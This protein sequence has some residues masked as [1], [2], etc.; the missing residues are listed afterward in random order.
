MNRRAFIHGLGALTVA[1]SSSAHAFDLELQGPGKRSW[2][3]IPSILVLAAEDDPRVAAVEQAVRAW[4]IELFRMGSGFRLGAARHR[5]AIIGA[6]AA[7]TVYD[8]ARGDAQKRQRASELRNRFK[9]IASDIIIVLADGPF[10]GFHTPLSPRPLKALIAICSE[11]AHARGMPHVA[12]HELGHAI[13]L[14]HVNDPAALMC[15][16]RPACRLFAGKGGLP[17]TPAEQRATLDLYPADWQSEMP[18]PDKRA[19]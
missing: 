13:G 12:A 9:Q 10:L 7:R 14:Q 8:A 18:L 3:R 4:N 2:D 6:D 1:G 17:L 15:D 11:P 5:V 16:G 19:G